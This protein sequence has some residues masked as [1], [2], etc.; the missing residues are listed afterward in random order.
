M[1]SAALLRGLGI[2]LLWIAICVT[3]MRFVWRLA[4]RHYSAV[5]N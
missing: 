2:Q 4:A 3:V 5:G 1:S